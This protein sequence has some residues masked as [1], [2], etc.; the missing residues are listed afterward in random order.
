MKRLILIMTALFVSVWIQAQSD[1]EALRYSE[2]QQLG[3]ARYLGTGGAFG[4]LGADFSSL[5]DNPAGVG[6]YRH[7]SLGFSSG[8]FG[9]DNQARYFGNIKNSGRGYLYFPNA[10][11]VYSQ[12]VKKGNWKYVN[13]GFA[14]NRLANFR[15][16]LYFEG[17]NPYNSMLQLFTEKLNRDRNT[18]PGDVFSSYPYDAGLAYET[19]L[20]D[21]LPGDT[22]RYISKIP[23]GGA[24]Q[25]STIL[26]S[27]KMREYLFSLA[28][29]YNNQLYLG[30]SL[31]V[32]GVQY[33][34]KKSFSEE[35]VMDTIPDFKS[36]TYHQDLTSTAS[37][38]QAK[39]G[40]IYW[41]TPDLRIGAALHTPGILNF[42]DRFSA[43]MQSD[44]ESDQYS[45]ETLP[46][47]FNYRLVTPLRI[48]L[49]A[50]K[51]F[52]KH[53]LIA[54][55][56]ESYDPGKT[57][58]YFPSGQPN[59]YESELNTSI[60]EKYQRVYKLK[61]GGELSLAALRLRA[62]TYWK[63]SVFNSAYNPGKDADQSEWGY[64]VGAGI[65]SQVFFV[66]AA[67]QS[68]IKDYAYVPYILDNPDETV[69]GAL[70][71]ERQF[72]FVLTAGITF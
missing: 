12:K 58:Y 31:S 22:F 70:V 27:G 42:E 36:Y 57:R 18:A 60:S 37:G 55:E 29:N 25:S 8:I 49:S 61:A 39:F 19:Y 9:Y 13:Y 67:L 66:D 20:I 71:K 63:S 44:I 28:A 34:E 23:Y 3:T 21:P 35:D 33:R 24:Q 1:V 11:F 5:S 15:N 50:A 47:R 17:V 10:G 43:D 26:T 48:Q 62:G 40:I 56:L 52:G 53:G 46:G 69:G 32:P 64:S 2:Y 51:L 59:S 68:S 72:N 54:A 45:Y 30:M 16:E 38:V 7:S 4:A 65:R 41:I 6:V 14:A